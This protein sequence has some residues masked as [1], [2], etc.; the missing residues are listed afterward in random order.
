[1]AGEIWGERHV[2]ARRALRAGAVT[3]AYRLAKDHGLTGGAGFAD[4]EWLAGWIALRFLKENRQALDHFER[5]ADAVRLPVSRAKAAYW[6]ALAAEGNG[7]SDRARR[8]WGEAARYPTTFYGQLAI[9]RLDPSGILNV[10]PLPSASTAEEGAFRDNELRRAVELLAAVDD[11]ARAKLFILRLGEI[12]KTPG[13]HVLIGRLGEAMGR[14]EWTVQAAKRAARAGIFLHAAGFPVISTAASGGQPEPALVHA[15]SRQ[16]SEF[17]HRAVSRAGALG[18]MQLMPRTAQSVARGLGVPYAQ[19]RLL[20]DPG[21]NMRLGSSYLEQM[22]KRYGGSYVLASAAYNA[23]PGRV[24]QWLRENG[25]PRDP[26][27][28]VV[29]WIELIPIEET[30]N[31]VARVLENLQVYRQKLEGAP[32][33][34]AEDLKRGSGRREIAEASD[35]ESRPELRP[36]APA[37]GEGT[38][39]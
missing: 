33:R 1:H 8:W 34:L 22:I 15:I 14:N 11:R 30:R 37:E 17:D 10:P 28:D 26:A 23:G 3:D 9:L 38:S 25:D 39:P 19:A 5:L 2:L 18:L 36:E 27:I 12:S 16:E 29:D 31:Y 24:A 7:N 13:E 6:S 21:Y 4:A 32:V 35:A 20:D